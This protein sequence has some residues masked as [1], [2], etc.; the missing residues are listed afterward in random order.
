MKERRAAIALL[1]IQL[2]LVLSIAGKYLYERKTCPRV[3]VKTAQVDPELPLRGRYLALRL[4][5]DTCSLPR[6]NE[7]TLGMYSFDGAQ[8]PRT[9]QWGVSLRESNG[10]LVAV[11]PNRPQ[12][13][14]KLQQLYVREGE[15][16]E[17]V[18]LPTPVEYFVPEHAQDPLRP[19]SGDVL[20][21]EVTV[22]PV[23]PPRPIQLALSGK[24][25]F[26]PLR[27]E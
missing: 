25:G 23:G 3:W 4:T 24:D 26:R 22:P 5:V 2:V 17:A 13:P 7:H 27:F 21:V 19:H 1:L 18:R 9:F 6:D 15:P 11:L 12:S 8:H 14:D 16:C 10:H 20:W